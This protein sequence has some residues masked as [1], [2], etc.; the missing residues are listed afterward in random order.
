[1]RSYWAVTLVSLRELI[2]QPFFTITLFGGAFFILASPVFTMFTFLTSSVM[3]MDM[4]LSTILVVALSLG[5]LFAVLMVARE[6]EEKTTVSIL[7]KPIS[8]FTFLTAKL[9]A[10]CIAILLAIIPLISILIM[11]LRLGVPEAA[12]SEV[13]YP[14]LWMEFG[15]LVI[16]CIIG[17]LGNYY[18]DKNFTS[19][20]VISLNILYILFLF[21]LALV[22]EEFKFNPFKVKMHFELIKPALLIWWGGSLF[23]ALAL[24]FSLSGRM[25]LALTLSLLIALV[26]LSADFLFTKMGKGNW[27]AKALYA[28]IPN[29][30]IFWAQEFWERE[31]EV[32]LS[33]LFNVLRYTILYIAGIVFIAWGV[34]ERKEVGV[35]RK[36]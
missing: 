31:K 12:Y 23:A 22:D 30:Q 29:L 21:F 35:G 7:S 28:L 9:T 25:M 18:A 33:Y 2:R 16:A 19:L 34:W 24:L 11:T 4:G 14:V 15:P 13:E 8:R 26:G 36:G 27:W 1:M 32:P 6:V 10:I 20:F 17:A 5:V 3:V